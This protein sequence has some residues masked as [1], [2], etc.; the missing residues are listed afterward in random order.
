MLII[1]IAGIRAARRAARRAALAGPRRAA[2]RAVESHAKPHRVAVLWG[3]GGWGAAR[4]ERG[5]SRAERGASRT[6]MGGHRAQTNVGSASIFR[7][8]HRDHHS[9]GD[10]TIVH[11]PPP[12]G[13]GAEPRE[14]KI[15]FVRAVLL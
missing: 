12:Q 13:C 10:P 4:A 6:E 1:G 2:H 15:S 8:S 9:Q 7:E 3:E 14:E 11:P 5:A